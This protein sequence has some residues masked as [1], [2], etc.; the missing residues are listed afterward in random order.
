[1]TLY[2]NPAD[3]VAGWPAPHPGRERRDVSWRCDRCDVLW[4]SLPRCWVCGGPGVAR[5]AAF[6][7]REESSS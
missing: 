3:A 4:R 7:V 5:I 1:M 6:W 2:A